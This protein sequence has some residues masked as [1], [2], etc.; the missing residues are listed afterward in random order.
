MST[1]V[2]FSR[3]G[4]ILEIELARPAKKN[5][6]TGAMYAAI[7][8]R[9]TA[10]ETDPA[11][12]VLLFHGQGDSFT[13]GNDLNDFLADPPASAASPVCRFMRALLATS[14]IAIVAAHGSAVG[15]G[16]TM[17]LHCDLVVASRDARFSL[18]FVNL[19]L[20]PEYASSLLLPRLIGHRRAAEL[21]IL[22]H[23]FDAVTAQSLGL[24]NRVVDG[25]ALLD[26]A[27]DLARE[28][29]SR[30]PA[31]VRRAKALMR[32]DIGEIETRIEL[33][34]QAF[35]ECLRAPEF[36]EAAAAFLAKRPPDFSAFI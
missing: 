12:R 31:A 15:I 22:G 9:L 6:L 21:L 16:T 4:P 23:P 7:A 2:V 10:A 28:V 27:R 20:V 24:V 36:R 3:S 11:L 32:G 8:D 14:K 25:A 33:E 1:D 26:Q 18:P 13:S 17:L 34:I 19:G 35:A 29:A 5:A 30:P